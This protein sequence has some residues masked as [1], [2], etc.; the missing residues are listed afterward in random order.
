MGYTNKMKV[1]KPITLY[2]GESTNNYSNKFKPLAGIFF[3]PNLKGAKGWGTVVKYTL[4]PDANIFKYKSSGSYIADN[5]FNN[6]EYSEVYELAKSLGLDFK[7]M[8]EFDNNFDYYRENGLEDRLAKNNK[9]AVGYDV[10]DWISQI[11]SRVELEKNGYD[12][13]KWELED[14]GNP[15]QF[16]IWNMDVIDKINEHLNE[17]RLN[18]HQTHLE[19]LPT[20][21]KNGLDE[22]NSYIDKFISQL[23]GNK[24]LTLMSKIDGAPSVIMWHNIGNGY[25][26]NSIAL[27]S[28]VN[29]PKT[30]LST[31]EQ[32]DERY[33]DRPD[34]A[35]K[36]KWC[37]ELSKYIPNGEAWQGDCLFTKNDLKEEEIN[38]IKYLTFHPNK[39]VYA[40]SED[41]PGY[42]KVKNADL[43]IAFHTIYTINNGNISQSFDVDNLKINAPSNFYL[44]FHE[45]STEG[46]EQDFNIDKLN[47]EYLELKQLEQNLINDHNYEDL[48]NNKL[49][50]DY[51][52]TFE[53]KEFADNKKVNI[54]INTVL[55]D[56]KNYISNKKEVEYN[57]KIGSLKT[58][59]GKENAKVKYENELKE[60]EELLNNNKNTII[61]LVKVINKA[62]DIKMELW[63]SLNKSKDDFSTF[64]KSKTKGYIPA[65]REGISMSDK[66]GNL[67]KIVDRSEFSSNN[68]NPDFAS[69]FEHE[70]LQEDVNIDKLD[71]SI[72]PILKKEL[73]EKE[74]EF[75][76]TIV[77]IILDGEYSKYFNNGVYDESKLKR[78]YA[79]KFWLD[80]FGLDTSLKGI[81]SA[82]DNAL[83]QIDSVLEDEDDYKDTLDWDDADKLSEEE[84]FKINLYYD[85]DVNVKK[86]TWGEYEEDDP[87]RKLSFKEYLKHLLDTNEYSGQEKEWLEKAI[88]EYEQNLFFENLAST[89]GGD[90][91]SFKSFTKNI[92]ENS[93]KVA[94]VAV[95]RMNPPTI[96]HKALVNA[97]SKIGSKYGVKPKLFLTHSSNNIKNPLSYESKLRWAEKAFGDD[98]EIVKSN[99][100]SIIE[101][102]SELYNE[103]YTKIVYAG[104]DK[105]IGGSEDVT[106]LI[107]YY[108]K[109]TDKK[110]NILYRFN[111]IEYEP[112]GER[113]K[114]TDGGEES[115]GTIVRKLAAEKN[116]DEFKKYVPFNEN[117]AK[118][119]FNELRYALKDYISIVEKYLKEAVNRINS[120]VGNEIKNLLKNLNV[121]Y[122]S[123]NFSRHPSEAV[124]IVSLDSKNDL[125]KNLKSAL[126]KTKYK[127]ILIPFNSKEY[128]I[129]DINFNDIGVHPEASKEYESIPVEVIS[130]D[131][132][133]KMTLYISLSTKEDKKSSAKQYTPN[134]VLKNGIGS[135]VNCNRLQF[136][137]GYSELESIYREAVKS[138]KG[139][140][141]GFEAF[142][143]DMSFVND[144]NVNSI[145]NDFGE[146]LSAGCLAKVLGKP[147]ELY[148]PAASNEKLIDFIVNGTI[149]VSQKAGSGASPSGDSIIELVSDPT[150]DVDQILSGE[151]SKKDINRIKSFIK[152]FR[153]YVFD[154]NVGIH[155][156]F[157]NMTNALINNKI[158]FVNIPNMSSLQK[159]F[160]QNSVSSKNISKFLNDI[161]KY[162]GSRIKVDEKR[163]S[164]KDYCESLR[165]RYLARILIIAVNDDNILISGLNTIL[166]ACLGEFI[167]VYLVD[168]KQFMQ[169][170]MIFKVKK[171]DSKYKYEFVDG[172]AINAAN[173]IGNKKLSMK[174]K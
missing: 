121:E 31:N 120:L 12:G 115:S 159:Y 42:N 92:N 149:K 85:W 163:L 71:I 173:K 44:L 84:Q 108:N 30:A 33:G 56:L 153:T 170:H 79:H 37:L 17:V 171:L 59:Q 128:I 45:M 3:S 1:K 100:R 160:K 88:K 63:R 41:N 107:D 70:S 164:N 146:V 127:N 135:F 140:I 114:P 147:N 118:N 21:G 60:L 129:K 154:K 72:K 142:V 155:D 141:N 49:F 29:G 25:P 74:K 38:N 126:S 67:V 6:K 105:R 103:G 20:L 110:G 11:V 124:R 122:R 14:F 80:N 40:F 52:N 162:I 143:N 8:E 89:Q 68:R 36:L 10:Y 161:G 23:N 15:N 167:Q 9:N 93:D 166:A 152:F 34:M 112:T 13:V 43:G 73:K 151:Y 16:Q 131:N 86:N 102:L 123:T 54:D 91:G 109:N 51:W 90:M 22:L 46:K 27:K 24:E 174:L 133:D 139:N 2:R 156:G 26:N 113:E 55:N 47:K 101:F 75:I 5:N 157:V 97:L 98:V 35:R 78:K 18:T 32:I 19:S 4:S 82:I 172:S 168:P 145:M 50:I 165:I 53:N 104:D 65:N 76:K 96:G 7:S 61:N 148:F 150:I 77:K 144:T 87:I 111:E 83:V 137:E 158:N 106:N 130:T 95:G 64:Y 28:F 69:G 94:V 66:D 117:D 116:F 62:A 125:I 169:G 48:V 57:K 81:G 58:D 132:K 134:K 119:L 39:I 136:A 138:A 99:A